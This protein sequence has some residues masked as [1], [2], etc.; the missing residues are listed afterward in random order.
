MF[1]YVTI[2]QKCG[3]WASNSTQHQKHA[4][5]QL[6][7]G[8]NTTYLEE[9]QVCAGVETWG[10]VCSIDDCTLWRGLALLSTEVV[11]RDKSCVQVK[12][13]P[14]DKVVVKLDEGVKGVVRSPWLGERET[15]LFVGILGLSD[16]RHNAGRV[17]SS[18]DLEGN[19]R[20]ASCLNLK[21]SRTDWV[22]LAQQVTRRLAEVLFLGEKTCQR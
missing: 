11:S 6:V 3:I 17:A 20:W 21:A 7:G 10:L 16:G 8:E 1:R 9:V 14:R 18:G 2:T 13:E 5:V 22:V 19:T 4:L 12:L 15:L